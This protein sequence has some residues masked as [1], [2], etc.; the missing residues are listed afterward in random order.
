MKKERKEYQIQK[1]ALATIKKY[2]PK[3]KMHVTLNGE[4]FGLETY[5]K[6]VAKHRKLK[7]EHFEEGIQDVI[8]FIPEGKVVNIEF[9]EPTKGVQSEE[10]KKI[11]KELKDLDH[12]YYIATNT[13]E[14]LNALKENLSINY[15]KEQKENNKEPLAKEFIEKVYI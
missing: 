3:L 4:V 15:I 14:A 12:N 7:Q 8:I 10:Q 9:K 6:N 11:E 5:S 13:I 2:Y 1:D